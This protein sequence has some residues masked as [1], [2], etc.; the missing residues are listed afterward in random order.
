MLAAAS[1]SSGAWTACARSLL[2]CMSP[3]AF[4]AGSSGALAG[5]A[6]SHSTAAAAAAAATPAVWQQRFDGIS[7]GSL[8]RI[9][10]DQAVAD[11]AVTVGEHEAIELSGSSAALTASAAP[12]AA[13]AGA[14]IG[15]LSRTTL[16]GLAALP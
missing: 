15:A 3:A 10:L 6:A 4:S 2:Q 5:A 11:V 13:H 7:P 16:V 12:H 1:R 9:E 8:L 14:S